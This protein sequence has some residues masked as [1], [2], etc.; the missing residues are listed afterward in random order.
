MF[1]NHDFIYK[2]YI[3]LAFVSQTK[4]CLT[5]FVSHSNPVTKQDKNHD[6]TALFCII[7]FAILMN[8]DP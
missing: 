5:F 3:I 4:K 1:L 2:K 6:R 8:D 7:S